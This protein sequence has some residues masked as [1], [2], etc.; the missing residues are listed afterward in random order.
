LGGEVK[1]ILLLDVTPLSLGVE[2]LGGVMTV[3]IPRNTTIPTRKSETFSTAADNQPSVEIHVMQGERKMAPDNR[4]LGKFHLMGIPPAPRGTPQIEV[5]F[6]IDA[7]G[8]LNVSA[9]DHATN[10]EQKITITASTG[11]S[12]EE[13]EKMRNDAEAHAEEDKKKLAEIEA[14]NILDNRVYQIE[15][16]L[17]E[18]REKLSESDIKPVEEALAAAKSALAGGVLEQIQ[19]ATQ[20]L[21]RASHSLA[22]TLYKS[23]QASGAQA[24]AGSSDGGQGTP[25]GPKPGAGSGP[26][27]EGV[28]DAEYVD[29][30]ES[31]KP[32]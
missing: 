15:K 29:V 17:N 22:E 18:N 1:D 9:K 26:G 2:T 20:Q 7:N 25:G 4:T 11:L 14:R 5:T 6:D 8:I 30:D 21:E 24:G 27:G 3:L 28:I 31:K 16:L 12:K 10:K 32:N 19:S 23:A 13:A